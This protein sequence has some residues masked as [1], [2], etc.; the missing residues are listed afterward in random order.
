MRYGRDDWTIEVQGKWE[1]FDD[2][3][4]LTLVRPEGA[5]QFSSAKRTGGSIDMPEI[6][7]VASKCG[8][9]NWGQSKVIQSDE[10]SGLLFDHYESNVHWLRWFLFQDS[11]LVLVTYNS[12]VETSEQL[13]LEI[14]AIIGTLKLEPL[15]QTS[16]VHRASNA[17]RSLITGGR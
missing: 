9:A 1:L 10:F 12:E 3:Q 4:C 17:L 7:R 2:P 6:G 8:S 16:F 14:L 11:T 5:L 15:R 13:W